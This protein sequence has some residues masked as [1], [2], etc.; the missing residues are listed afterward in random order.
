MNPQLIIFCIV[1]L[2][3]FFKS[4]DLQEREVRVLEDRHSHQR[5]QEREL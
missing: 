1:L 2:Y 4:R 5:E 3:E